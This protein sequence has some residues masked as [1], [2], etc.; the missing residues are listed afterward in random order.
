MV[1]NPFKSAVGARPSSLPR[2]GVPGN[3]PKPGTFP[4]RKLPDV[5]IPRSYP[6]PKT[7]PKGFPSPWRPP[8]VNFGRKMPFAFEPP[9]WPKGVKLPWMP[10]AV[11]GGMLLGWYLARQGGYA[12]PGGWVKCWDAGGPKQ[13]RAGPSLAWADTCSKTAGDYLL[14]LQVPSGVYGDPIHVNAFPW[15]QAI[16]FG[17]YINPEETRM[18][19][20]EKWMHPDLPGASGPF[21][22]EYRPPVFLPALPPLPWAPNWPLISPMPIPWA[23]PVTPVKPR[24]NPNPNPEPTPD[25]YGDPVPTVTPSPAVIP[26]TDITSDG[27]VVTP[28]PNVHVKEPPVW[29]D[30]E[31]KKRLSPKES[32][33]WRAALE[34]SGTSYMELDDFVSAIYKGLPWQVRRWRGRDGVWRDRDANTA[35]RM[36]RIYDLFGQLDIRQAIANVAAQEAADRVLGKIGQTLAD[37]AR[38]LGDAGLYHRPVGF[39]Y[40]NNKVVDNWEELDRLR[41]EDAARALA[42]HVRTY[43][44]KRYDAASNR[45]YWV[46]KQRPVTQIPWFRQASYYPGLARPGMGEYWDLTE[47]EKEA[48]LRTVRRYYYAPRAT[49]NPIFFPDEK[50]V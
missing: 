29:P 37:R 9:G 40:G 42:A 13:A 46:E 18:M 2:V 20:T 36:S 33:L 10:A 26:S 47:A 23:P 45:W 27:P 17:P 31:K 4:R 32:A 34:A 39:Q 11:A 3:Y 48:R 49:Y 21:D 12:M 38:A 1:A 41:K 19:Y 24:P 44:V 15:E 8:K 6:L 50:K 28:L 22:I 25:P 43:K 16:W 7:T 5:R 14:S 35:D 30:K